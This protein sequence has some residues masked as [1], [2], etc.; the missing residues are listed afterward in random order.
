MGRG[1]HAGR[2][3]ARPSSSGLHP[4]PR[5]LTAN[6]VGQANESTCETKM[7]D[8]MNLL[9]RLSEPAFAKDHVIRPNARALGAVLVAFNLLSCVRWFP[10]LRTVFPHSFVDP[11]TPVQI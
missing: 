5:G 3:L 11:V 2:A 9:D 6:D 8:K 7:E 10:E 4:G 1:E